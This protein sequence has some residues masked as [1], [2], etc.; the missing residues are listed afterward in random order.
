MLKILV[1]VTLVELMFLGF[2][3]V[4]W[5]G[6]VWCA[7]L[8]CAVRFG[9]PFFLSLGDV[10]AMLVLINS[11]P[12]VPQTEFLKKCLQGWISNGGPLEMTKTTCTNSRLKLWKQPHFSALAVFFELGASK[13]LA[14]GS[15]SDSST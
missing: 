9:Y 3:G 6:V 10:V 11:Q 13:H 5:C 4:V 8:C 2:V 14:S 12:S 1:R 7:V 15:R